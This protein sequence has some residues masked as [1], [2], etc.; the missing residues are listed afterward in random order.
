MLRAMLGDLQ[1]NLESTCKVSQ[2][3]IKFIIVEH[4][5]EQYT[6]TTGDRAPCSPKGAKMLACANPAFDGPEVL[7]QDI[8][9]VRYLRAG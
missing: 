8:I 2:H 7:F 3:D 1:R 9:E 6:T 4:F 5:R